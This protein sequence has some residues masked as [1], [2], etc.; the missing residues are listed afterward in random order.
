MYGEFDN[1]KICGIAS[2]APKRVVDNE[3]IAERLGNRRA[4]NR[5]RSQ[6]LSTGILWTRGNQQQ[7][8][9]VC[10]ARNY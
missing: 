4:K 1:I 6:E 5:L 8:L 2:A 7:T 10:A 3:I 9:V